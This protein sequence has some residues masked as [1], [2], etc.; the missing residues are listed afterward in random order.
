MNCRAQLML[1]ASGYAYSGP[2]PE[3]MAEEGG[4][5]RLVIPPQRLDD[6]RD[7][8]LRGLRFSEGR[9]AA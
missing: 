1:A 8:Y 6:L 2:L 4:I 3:D 7:F 9:G 5:S